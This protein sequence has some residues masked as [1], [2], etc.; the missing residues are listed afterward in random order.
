MAKIKPLSKYF[1]MA[2]GWQV[3]KPVLMRH[4]YGL[5]ATNLPKAIQRGGIGEQI[6]TV[7]YK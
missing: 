5:C 3:R 2:V 4:N 6:L 7:K 1:V